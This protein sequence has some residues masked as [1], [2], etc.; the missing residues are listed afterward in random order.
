MTRRDL[1][2]ALALPAAAAAQNPPA[3]PAKEDL[4]EAAR[5][6]IRNNSAAL[7]KYKIDIALEPA[8][9]FKA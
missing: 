5:N 7:A 3:E 1:G 8:F 4:L 2:L 6:Q 9:Q